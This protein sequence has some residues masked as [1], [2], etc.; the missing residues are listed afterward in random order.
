MLVR[1]RMSRK[2]VVVAPNC[3]LDAARALLRRHHMRQVPVLHRQQLVG[4]VT[5]RDLRAAPPPASTVKEIMADKPITIAPDAPVDEAARLLRIH[6]M[7]AL[8]VVE[9]RRVIGII[10]ATDIL[11]AFIELSGVAERTYRLEVDGPRRPRIEIDLRHL[12]EHMHGEVRW[13]HRDAQRRGRYHLRLKC[14][15]IDD[16]VTALEAA[17]FEVCAVVAPPRQ[18]L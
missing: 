14:R 13:V 2:V 18:Q 17:G 16:V 7:N 10:T 12:I 15:N 8:P 5:D 3:S 1:Y 9:R 4:I 6:K 11:N